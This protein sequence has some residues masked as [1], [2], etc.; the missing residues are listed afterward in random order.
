MNRI[1]AVLGGDDGPAV[2]LWAAVPS[3]LTAEAAAAAGADYVVVDEQH[4]TVGPGLMAA[5]L[6]GISAG[7]AAGLV[8]VAANDAYAIGSALDLGAH[9]VIVPLVD[10]AEEAAR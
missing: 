10:S 5:M 4:G 1:R 3:S 9:G 2:G 7:G 6:Q 8:R